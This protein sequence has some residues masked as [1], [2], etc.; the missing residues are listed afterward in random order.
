MAI[1]D[2]LNALLRAR[3]P[4][5]Y[6]AA[7]AQAFRDACAGFAE[8]T[9]DTV[10]S[11][12]ATVAGTGSGPSLAVIGHADEIGL[13]VHHID[14]KGFLW[15]KPVGGWDAQII[16]GQRV[17]V[18]TRDG[19]LPGTVGR[20]PIHLLKGD[21]RKEVVELENL[22][23]DIGASG[24]EEARALVRLGDVA[25]P[26][27]DPAE[28]PN[29]RVMARA[30]DNRVGCFVA[31]EVA[32]RVA[33][34]GGAAGDVYAVAVSQEE[35]TFGG[36]LTTAFSLQPDVAVVVDGCWATD[37]PG[38]DESKTGRFRLGDGAI[39]G[40][41]TTLSPVLFEL[42]HDTAEAEGIPF[43]LEVYGGNTGTDADAFHKTAHGIPCAV[44]SVPMRYLHSPSE[45]CDL[46]D[47]EA[48][49]ALITAFAQRLPADLDLRR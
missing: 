4:S 35:T 31:A 2:T 41:G 3:G 32:R 25:V 30:L 43:G 18:I 5:G 29:G 47:V 23:I 26:D 15:F 42:L 46:A 33:E 48:A 1:P 21:A 39:I 24:E 45:L 10:G 49:V 27:A 19:A 20:K 36:A 7:P 44:V 8:V 13:I 11:T 37:Q 9:H 40:R 38:I 14:D 22:H 17:S 34:A 28:L 16:V 12:V 6:E